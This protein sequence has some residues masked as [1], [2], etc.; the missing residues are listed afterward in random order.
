[1]ARLFMRSRQLS[2]WDLALENKIQAA[3]DAVK[4]APDHHALIQAQREYARL[5]RLQKIGIRAALWR[6]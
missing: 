2:E 6:A 3:N 5:K 1:M 4:S